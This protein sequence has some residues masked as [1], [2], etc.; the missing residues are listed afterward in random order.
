MFKK[1]ADVVA[2]GAHPDW[3]QGIVESDIF[4]AEEKE[5]LKSMLEDSVNQSEAWTERERNIVERNIE[6][7]RGNDRE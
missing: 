1:I 3:I 7:L 6:N 5:V 2:R 4:N